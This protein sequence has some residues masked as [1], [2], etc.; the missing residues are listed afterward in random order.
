MAVKVIRSHLLNDQNFQNLLTAELEVLQRL[1]HQNIVEFYG[2]EKTANS[3]YLIF[4][5]CSGG[6]L[7]GYLKTHGPLT[8]YKA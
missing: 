8:E 2:V 6:D 5:L 3:L 1:R 4:Q 7:K